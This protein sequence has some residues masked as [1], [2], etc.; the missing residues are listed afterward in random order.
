[1]VSIGEET[2]PRLP[3]N[4]FPLKMHIFGTQLRRFWPQKGDF[5]KIIKTSTKQSYKFYK[6]NMVSISEEMHPALPENWFSLKMHIFG[7]NLG[8]FEPKKVIFPRSLKLPQ[9]S[10]ITS[11]QTKNGKYWWKNVAC[12]AW[13]QII[14]KNAYFWY[15]TLAF[16]LQKWDFSKILQTSTKQPYNKPTNQK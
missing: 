15:A 16:W 13:K 12:T 1:M 4:W 3:K 11:L 9:N 7:T 6:P 5:S 2:N 8:V 14:S 10:L